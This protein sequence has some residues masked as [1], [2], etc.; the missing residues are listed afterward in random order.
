MTKNLIAPKFMATVLTVSLAISSMSA[1]PAMAKPNDGVR[2]LQGL[3]AL[4]VI[5]RVIKHNKRSRAHRQVAPTVPARC[6][7]TFYTR[8][9]QTRAYTAQ[10]LRKHAPR[11]SLPQQ[12]KRRIATDYG[13]RNVYGPNCLRQHGYRVAHH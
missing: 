13:R 5:S 7:K 11:L 9:G 1:V 3:A 10:C 12:C 2:I 4:Y 6:L 8:R